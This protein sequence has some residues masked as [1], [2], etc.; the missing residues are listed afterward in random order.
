MKIHKDLRFRICG[1]YL[2]DFSCNGMNCYHRN[3]PCEIRYALVI[4]IYPFTDDSRVVGV[5]N[6]FVYLVEIKTKSIATEFC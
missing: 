3:L 1:Q 4:F 5:C 2:K 6:C